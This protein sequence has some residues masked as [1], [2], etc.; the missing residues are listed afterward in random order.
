MKK[1]KVSPLGATLILFWVGQWNISRNNEEKKNIRTLLQSNSAP[2]VQDALQRINVLT[3]NDMTLDESM[4]DSIDCFLLMMGR[5]L[6]WERSQ[7]KEDRAKADLAFY[8]DCMFKAGHFEQIPMP[9]FEWNTGIPEQQTP[10]TP[11]EKMMRE[12]HAHFH[13][14]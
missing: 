4:P 6:D 1:I 12:S 3:L 13:E 8:L 14:R 5:L 10:E 2:K 9:E 11:Y 7:E